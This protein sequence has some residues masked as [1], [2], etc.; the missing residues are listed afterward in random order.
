MVRDLSKVMSSDKK[1]KILR[2]ICEKEYTPTKL[3]EEFEMT[4]G[5]MNRYFR[6]LEDA[7][8]I[9]LVVIEGMPGPPKQVM[10]TE[11]IFSDKLG[12]PFLDVP[13]YEVAKKLIKAYKEA[14]DAPKP[15]SHVVG[16]LKEGIDNLD[17]EKS[18]VSDDLNEFIAWLNRA[19]RL[20]KWFLY[21][22]KLF[23][24]KIPI[25]REWKEYP[26]RSSM[27]RET[28]AFHLDL[29]GYLEVREVLREGE[30]PLNSREYISEF[31]IGQEEELRNESTPL[32]K[33][34]IEIIERHKKE[35]P[36]LS[37]STTKQLEE[38]IEK[39]TIMLEKAR[40]DLKSISKEKEEE[41][42][43]ASISEEERNSLENKIDCYLE[44]V[45]LLS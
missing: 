38:G 36:D 12:F 16:A 19:W 9:K 23:V 37:E 30:I 27:I 43:E 20:L 28:D 22:Q 33:S 8:L 17:E 10:P 45:N 29:S 13:E 14:K 39:I 11:R 26:R 7:G 42:R 24:E 31:S 25:T 2:K 34:T 6:E 21:Y 35:I 5:G 41:E 44:I 18:D 15:T 1:L 3:A 32:A 40:T 4:R